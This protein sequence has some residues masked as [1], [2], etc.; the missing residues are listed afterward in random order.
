MVR[1]ILSLV[2][3]CREEVGG[4]GPRVATISLAKAH[5]V[6][7]V[8]FQEGGRIARIDLLRASNQEMQRFDFTAE[9]NIMAR[10]PVIFLA[11]QYGVR[12]EL[13]SV[14]NEHAGSRRKFRLRGSRTT[15]KLVS[16]DTVYT[17]RSGC[18]YAKRGGGKLALARGCRWRSD[19]TGTCVGHST[20]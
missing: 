10:D 5:S 20:S 9:R 19:R 17:E 13:G 8:T 7:Y 6:K 18:R 1:P 16:E 11:G 12:G 15:R 2:Q 14:A 4:Q 3:Q